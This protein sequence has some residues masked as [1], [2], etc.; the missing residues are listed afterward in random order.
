MVSTRWRKASWPGEEEEAPMSVEE[1]N[2]ALVR[3]FVEEVLNGGNLDAIDE[4][5]APDTLGLTRF[6]EP[7]RVKQSGSTKG[8]E[9][10]GQDRQTLLA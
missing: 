10:D 5:M 4:L 1:D 2:K 3:R 6:R 9:E 7:I 8:V